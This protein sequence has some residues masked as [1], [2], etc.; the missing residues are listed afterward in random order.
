[1]GTTCVAG[2]DL[3]R[4]GIALG[5]VL[6]VPLPPVQ[7]L[8]LGPFALGNFDMKDSDLLLHGML[9]ATLISL[10]ICCY[11]ALPLFRLH[12][13]SLEHPVCLPVCPV[14]CPLVFLGRKCVPVELQVS[15]AQAGRP[16][17]V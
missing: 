1:M 17:K 12:S 11:L 15:S 7:W 2:D 4:C 6:P 14:D 16:R 9:L 8:F 13:S 5:F 3:G 10:Y